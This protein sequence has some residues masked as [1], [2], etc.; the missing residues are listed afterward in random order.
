MNTVVKLGLMIIVVWL[1][2]RAFVF[3]YELLRPVRQALAPLNDHVED[4][5]RKTGL[6]KL[7][8]VSRK[9]EKGIDAAVQ[10]QIQRSS[11]K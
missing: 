9:V 5:M 11:S 8:D 3:A 10:G 1:V 2:W 4:C 7:A 6:G